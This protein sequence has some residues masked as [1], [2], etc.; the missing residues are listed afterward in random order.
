MKR[1]SLPLMIALAAV[2]QAGFIQAAELPV[3]TDPAT[4]H[5]RIGFH[6]YG[7]SPTKTPEMGSV[8]RGGGV[9]SLRAAVELPV[10]INV[11]NGIGFRVSFLGYYHQDSALG[12]AWAAP[13]PAD[14][15][16]D[17]IW[18]IGERPAPLTDGTEVSASRGA[19][20]AFYSFVIAFNY[21]LVIPDVPFFQFLQPFIG[22]GGMGTWLQNYVDIEAQEVYLIDN[23]QNNPTDEDNID[24]FSTQNQP[25]FTLYGGIHF[26]LGDSFRLTFELGGINYTAA[27][28][29]L[30][31]AT[32][33]Y[34]ARHLEY[35]VRILK[36]GGGLAGRF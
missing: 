2:V 18:E 9:D 8:I 32:E 14:D 3:T 4:Q 34:N 29:E 10:T 36:V 11:W 6:F 31:K 17:G 12:V 19:H 13:N 35:D 26:N 15:D 5:A 27:E 7:I 16:G 30:K 23:D 33:G 28:A 20:N 25:A 1:I 22:V 24:P 21:E